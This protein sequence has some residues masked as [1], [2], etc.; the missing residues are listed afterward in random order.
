MERLFRTWSPTWGD[1]KEHCL[2]VRD[3]LG[4]LSAITSALAYYRA[5][6]CLGSPLLR[7]FLLLLLPFLP[8][9]TLPVFSTLLKY[10]P[11]LSRHPLYELQLSNVERNLR[12][13]VLQIG[14][15]NDGCC[16]AEIF[17]AAALD[18]DAN[19]FMVEVRMGRA[20]SE[21]TM[22]PTPIPF[23]TSRTPPRFTRR[24]H[25][26]VLG[27]RSLDTPG[28]AFESKL[29]PPRPSAQARTRHQQ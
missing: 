15:V 23:L 28:A 9:L 6:I 17:R 3:E 20:R 7:F 27:R 26:L 10:V 2:S 21:A 24:C 8:L 12:S 13:C 1:C 18:K 11:F 19:V 25:F 14:G 29:S 22:L 5:N 4:N 16:K